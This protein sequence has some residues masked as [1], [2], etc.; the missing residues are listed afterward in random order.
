MNHTL[1][2]ETISGSH[3]TRDQATQVKAKAVIPDDMTRGANGADL[4]GSKI[5]ATFDWEPTPQEL[6]IMARNVLN[7]V[8]GLKRIN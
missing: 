6:N 4:Q 5:H 3:A 1:T 8:P 2:F 7:K